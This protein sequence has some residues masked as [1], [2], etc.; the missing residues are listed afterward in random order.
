MANKG[1]DNKISNII[2]T[3]IP[4]WL[5]QQFDTRAD[6]NSDDSR[7]NENLLY[8]SNKSAWVRL[9]SSVDINQ[10]R[11]RLFFNSNY[12]LNLSDP[13]SLAKNF[14]LF[15]GTSK[16]KGKNSY[17]LRSGVSFSDANKTSDGAYGILGKKEI[18]DYGYR[19]MPGITS[20]T[21][22]TQGRLGSIKAAIISFKCWD[23]LQLDIIDALY[24]KL[25]FTMFLEWGHTYFY[26]SD[27]PEKLKS[28]ED[29]SVLD[30]LEPFGQTKNPPTKEQIYSE[31]SKNNRDTEGN[32]DAML[33]MVTNFNFVYNQDGGYDCTLRLMGLGFLGESIK[34]NNPATLPNLLKEEIVLL[35]NTLKLLDENQVGGSDETVDEEDNP[36]NK[37]ILRILNNK[38]N[39]VDKEP[40]SVEKFRIIVDAGILN[41]QK[42]DNTPRENFAKDYDFIYNIDGSYRFFSQQFGVQIDSQRESAFVQ[43]ITLNKSNI[44]SVLS[45]AFLDYRNNTRDKEIINS[46]SKYIFEK[47]NDT[48]FNINENIFGDLQFKSK[49]I[50]YKS[51]VNGKI[52]YVKINVNFD[53]PRTAGEVKQ[54]LFKDAVSRNQ[55]ISNIPGT[56]IIDETKSGL[57]LK[58]ISKI[59]GEETYGDNSSQLV[60]S[61]DGNSTDLNIKNNFKNNFSVSVFGL[62]TEGGLFNRSNNYDENVKSLSTTV[63]GDNAYS[64]KFSG[65]YPINTKITKIKP[66]L[67]S[68]DVVTEDSTINASFTIELNDSSLIQEIVP[69]DDP[70]ILLG[71]YL[72]LQADANLESQNKEEVAKKEQQRLE[73]E[74]L[75]DQIS[76]SLSYQSALEL[77]LRTIQVHA[78]TRAIY[79]S[80]KPDKNI[81]NKV[82]VL[83]MTSDKEKE[84][85]KQIFSNGIFSPYIDSFRNNFSSVNI[86]EDLSNRNLTTE[87]RLELY[88][89]YGFLSSLLGNKTSKEEVESDYVDYSKLL[90]AFVIPYRISQELVAGVKTNHPVYVPFGLVL[91]L[92][93]H[94]CTIY[95]SKSGSK[96]QTPLVYV[97]YNPNLNFFLSNYQQLSTDPFKVLIPFEGTDD[98]YKKLFYEKVLTENKKAIKTNANDKKGIPLFKPNTEDLISFKLQEYCPIKFS[99]DRNGYRG[100]IMNILLSIDYL[101]D[102]VKQYSRRDGSNNVYLKPFIEDILTTINKSIGNF[103]S[104]RLSYNDSSNTFQIVDDQLV[105]TLD[106]EIPID[107]NANQA[108]VQN[109]TEIPLIGKNS[110]AKSIETR[111]DLSSKLG[112]YI[113]ISANKLMKDK[114]TLSKN[115]DPLGFMNTGFSDRYV[116]NRLAI[117]EQNDPVSQLDSRAVEAINFN[118]TITDFYSSAN[119]SDNDVPQATSYYIEK[120]S[121]IKNEESASLAS[122]L[123]PVGINFTTDGIGGLNMGQAFTVSEQLLPYS[124]TTKNRPGYIDNYNN[125]VGFAIVG[126][127]HNIENNQWNTSIRTNM[128]AVKDRTVYNF[129]KKKTEKL[130]ENKQ[131]FSTNNENV[132]GLTNFQSSGN[133]AAIK[134]RAAADKYK[135]GV[136]MTDNE[137]NALIAGIN[138]EASDKDIERA[139]IAAVILNRTKN[140]SSGV[141]GV[142]KAPG[143][144]ESVTGPKTDKYINGPGSSAENNIYKALITYL[145]Q[146][147]NK[148]NNFISANRDLFFKKGTNIPIDG[149]DQ[150]IYKFAIDNK[151][152]KIGG[153][154][155]G[156]Y[157]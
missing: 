148:Y 11:D 90:T 60:L 58:V 151:W 126:L 154:L 18:Q 24:F 49:E 31:I 146:I 114:S 157:K 119:P 144:F 68:N 67:E 95:D 150:S 53:R 142:L 104:F 62:D 107:P 25:G 40:D 23:K 93:N 41:S 112:S 44:F 36:K 133:E 45:N 78:L 3:K 118:S 106:K 66:N 51:P 102:L 125:Y 21:I 123:V 98:D 96:S 57:I 37:T 14:I 100:R 139:N 110:I 38:I 97:D 122:A 105:P 16:Y 4:Q 132:T 76:N 135:G 108:S 35:N 87:Q 43:K 130:P 82:Y 52:Y 19:P 83:Q 55:S 85:L 22:E 81:G 6:R 115:A 103:N 61:F 77:T 59:V 153:S 99:A 84:F 8:L 26:T 109:R 48:V 88:T 46:V 80:G 28:S 74:A 71:D 143:Q 116:T 140:G 91:M 70:N 152:E 120:M 138:A 73:Q 117:G 145:P 42:R 65:T 147:T 131:E 33:G 136:P 54:I 149:R 15:G 128:I 127:T 63:Q 64:F 47:E 30:V 29:Y 69:V 129:D 34:I 134:A 32:Y 92:L 94:I 155:F 124:Y 20:V 1:L 72:K 113:A 156:N 12:N 89:K 7:K 10:E 101:T 86:P 56:L 79:S 9:I 121:K 2:G 50:Y 17:E 13:D 111:T 137:W 27:E 75:I 39:K 141:V 5:I